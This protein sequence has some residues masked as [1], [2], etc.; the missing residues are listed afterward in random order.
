MKPDPACPPPRRC[1]EKSTTGH[2]SS[3]RSTGPQG[4]GSAKASRL[5]PRGHPQCPGGPASCSQRERGPGDEIAR[6]RACVLHSG[7]TILAG[8]CGKLSEHLPLGLRGWGADPLPGAPRLPGA[9][10]DPQTCPGP[11]PPPSVVIRIMGCICPTDERV[12]RGDRI[13]NH[14]CFQHL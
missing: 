7:R 14:L 5:R 1:P 2:T 3:R 12:G 13:S 9:L 10:S 6:L 4:G 11:P 8:L